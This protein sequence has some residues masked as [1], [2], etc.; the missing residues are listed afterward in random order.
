MKENLTYG[1]SEDGQIIRGKL[2]CYNEE[3]LDSK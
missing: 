1:V 2:F 3:R